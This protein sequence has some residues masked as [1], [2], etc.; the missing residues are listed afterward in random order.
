MGAV[1]YW[2]L[3]A[4]DSNVQGALDRLRA[5]EFEAG[6]YSLPL[7]APGFGDPAFGD[8]C[9]G[10]RHGSIAEAVQEGI[11]SAE[12]TRSILDVVRI[13]GLPGYGVAAALSSDEI[14]ETFGSD[15]P[16]RS[17]VD[18]A[19]DELFERLERG[20]CV[21]VVVYGRTAPSELLFAGYSYD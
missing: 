15:K 18:R 10:P 8:L 21:Y 7:S 9:P 12:G 3:V 20:Q 5:R 2:Y 17:D 1:P 4:Y 16:T 11:D 6:R 19:L 14:L 13:G